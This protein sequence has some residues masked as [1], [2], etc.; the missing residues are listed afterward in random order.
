[1]LKHKP[2]RPTAAAQDPGLPE[3]DFGVGDPAIRGLLARRRM[4]DGSANGVEI[5]AL[6]C[7]GAKRW[8]RVAT[9]PVR[10]ESGVLDAAERGLFYAA[11][12]EPEVAE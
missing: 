3:P 11:D 6:N 10:S 2:M 9:V 8:Q 5:R 7:G 12:I 4:L 1:M